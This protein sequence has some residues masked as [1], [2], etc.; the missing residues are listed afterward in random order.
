[1][2]AAAAPS[3][4]QAWRNALPAFTLAVLALVGLYFS[5]AASIVGIWHRSDTFAHGFLV[6]PIVLWLVWR[7]RLELAAITPRFSAA[8]AVLLALAAFAWLLGELA[9]VNALSQLAFV[10]MLA[11]LVPTVLGIAV[12]RVITFPLVFLFFGVPIGEFAMPQLMEWT[13]DF[14]VLALRV[15]GIPV[16]RE[17]L[18]FVIPSGNWSV[19]EACSGVR[20]IIASLTVG[21]L[22]AYLNYQ[23]SRRRALF[24]VVS[25]LVPVLANWLRAYMIVML[26]HVSGN[27]LA[28][29]VDHLIYGWVFF[30]V[31]IML[32]FFIGARWSEPEP[33]L[34]Q[35]GGRFAGSGAH[36]AVRTPVAAWALSVAG[37]LVILA[38]PHAGS[39]AIDRAEAALPAPVLQAP[40]ALSAGWAA[41]A[42]ASP[43][44]QPAFAN[45][46]ATVSARYVA[47]GQP[48]DLYVGFYR[49]QG[50]ERKLVS[51]ENVLVTS[52]DPQWA[53]VARG[54]RSVNVGAASVK[55]RTAELRGSPLAEQV[56]AVRLSVLQV[57]WINGTW[58]SSDILAKAYTA[59]YSLIGRG[60]DSAVVIVHT[61]KG[62]AGQGETAL[63]GF[64]QSNA[65]ALDAWLRATKP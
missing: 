40:A 60:D 48:V 26:G 65:A 22:F 19:V 25:L 63:A 8:S 54:S 23:S 20:Y 49:H 18:Q 64:M 52:K 3:P 39:W 46:S 2:T 62:D 55:M 44:W 36:A 28:V 13:A 14:T 30:G 42:A 53:Q 32:M 5:T 61:P 7:K 31:V 51:S 34:D 47:Q 29:G 38:I 15:T 11:L 33:D 37:V 6:L 59:L 9:A 27:K 10:A 17:G 12:A 43:V 21:T 41:S 1:M 16:Y 45:P 4:Q 57:Y 24:I 58:T 50:V 35:S 56:D